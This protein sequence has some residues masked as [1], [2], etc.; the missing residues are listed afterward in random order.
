LLF[1]TPHRPLVELAPEVPPELADIVAKAMAP[2]REHRFDSARELARELRRYQTGQLLASRRY[3]FGELVRHWMKRHRTALRIS[4]VAALVVVA[5]AVFA[6]VRIRRERDRA[7]ESQALAEREL[8]RAQGIVASRSAADPV[9]R[10]DAIVLGIKAVAPDLA[11]GPTPEAIQGLTDALTAGPPLVP[12]RHEGVI[13]WFTSV[14]D[15][16]IG[17][18]DARELVL[19][20]A[21]SGKLRGSYPSE[22]PQPERPR[23]SPDGR[24]VVVC[25]FDPIGEVIDLA[26]NKHITFKAAVDFAGCAFLSNGSLI[27]AADEIAVRDPET[28]AVTKQLALPARANTLAVHGNQVAVTT[29]DGYLW[30]WS[31]GEPTV[32]ATKLPLG[33]VTGFDRSGKRFFA[34]GSDQ[35][36]RAFD[37]ANP[38]AAPIE[39]YRDEHSQIGSLIVDSASERLSI[40]SWDLDGGR[41]SRILGAE[42]DLD[43]AVQAWVPTGGWAVVDRAGPLALTD[44]ATRGTVLPMTAHTGETHMVEATAD[45]I[46]SASREG[47]AFLWDVSSAGM[48][49]G[50]SGEIVTVA[51]RGDRILTASHDGTARVWS[52]ADGHSMA[53]LNSGA[54]ITTALWVDDHTVALGDLTGH[55]RTF[56]ATTGKQLSDRDAGSPISALA[57][58]DGTV[59]IGT[60]HGD[61]LL[62]SDR[63]IEAAPVTALAFDADHLFSA[64]TD[65]IVRSWDARTAMRVAESAPG[66][67][68]D[69]PIDQEGDIALVAYSDIVLAARPGGPTR[70]LDEEKLVERGTIDGRLVAEDGDRQLSALQDGTL[71]FS[72]KAVPRRIAGHRGAITAGAVGGDL[73][74]TASV[75]GTVRVWD[76]T[77]EHVR[78]VIS[79]PGLGTPTAVAF[80]GD[81]VVIGYA[82]GAVRM[83]PTTPAGALA[84][85][86][87]I[88]GRFDRRADVSPYCDRP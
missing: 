63:R 19:W 74:A 64:H 14:G 56:D 29:V 61:I 76:I 80:A 41:H 17:V 36:V 73:I 21:K 86:C 88:I 84:E 70:V 25:G 52:A 67:A 4:A 3:T 77:G 48:L 22:L 78:F 45:R 1:G 75:D 40:G 62:G 83:V 13:K 82:S 38:T 42:V 18:D 26:T 11:A 23:V 28:G 9:Q 58:H 5:L 49:L 47:A 65:G 71:V 24:R 8:R 55:V 30:M 20:D 6:F 66:E 59:A 32:V 87:A 81:N 46:A 12:L 27:T 60:L 2:E 15:T 51:V 39:A 68:V 34:G 31:G 69:R 43:G 10:M 85:A 50:H 33:G 79:T 7:T 16:L 53:V 57:V 72:S 54:E 35:V 37:V 44:I